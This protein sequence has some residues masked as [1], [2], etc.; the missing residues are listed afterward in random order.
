MT[1]EQ[2]LSHFTM[3]CMLAAPLLAVRRLTIRSHATATATA[4]TCPIAALT[5]SVLAHARCCDRPVCMLQG[6]DLTT[7]SNETLEILTA[8]ELIAINQDTLVIQAV[9]A[10]VRV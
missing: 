6:N 3:W 7:M 4:A 2:D 10:A 1:Y 8:P 5:L 9:V